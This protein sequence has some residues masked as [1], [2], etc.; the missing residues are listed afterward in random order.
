MKTN[1]QFSTISST[2]YRLFMLTLH[3]LH[4]M[5]KL[6]DEPFCPFM[7]TLQKDYT[8]NKLSKHII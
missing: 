7:K 2:Y 8:S 3:N 4:M 6:M 5:K 1:V